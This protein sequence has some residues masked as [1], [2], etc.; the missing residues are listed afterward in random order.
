MPLLGLSRR[1]CLSVA[2]GLGHPLAAG[3]PV[4]LSPGLPLWLQCCAGSSGRGSLLAAIP[5]QTEIWVVAGALSCTI[6]CWHRPMSPRALGCLPLAPRELV[7]LIGPPA[8]GIPRP[9][10]TRTEFA[11]QT[12]VS[13][14]PLV[15]Y[16]RKKIQCSFT[17]TS[18]E[19]ARKSDNR[20]PLLR[21]KH[22]YTKSP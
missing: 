16:F 13:I 12:R 21:K 2:C 22:K 4:L 18:I 3:G 9:R 14:I 19:R 20:K 15:T 5:C 6:G 11:D 1:G 10:R 8:D 7:S 17:H